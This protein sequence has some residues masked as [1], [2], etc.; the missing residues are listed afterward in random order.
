M[1]EVARLAIEHELIHNRPCKINLDK[2]EPQWRQKRGSFV[3]LRVDEKLRGCIGSVEA[4]WPLLEDVAHNARAAAT[5]DPR[6]DPVQRRE[7]AQL[8]IHIPV[9]SPLEEI[10]CCRR[11]GSKCL[12]RHSSCATSNTRPACRWT[13]GATI[14]GCGATRRNRWRNKIRVPPN[15]SFCRLLTAP[16]PPRVLPGTPVSA[17]ARRAQAHGRQLRQLV[18]KI[19]AEK[20]APPTA[21]QAPAVVRGAIANQVF[22]FSARSH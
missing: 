17:P 4:Q 8:R 3:T 13:I 21:C 16:T 18:Q 7:L 5:Q 22:N 11:C 1:L 2:Y 19:L 12:T 6:F 14:C 15:A 20:C 10:A 9:L